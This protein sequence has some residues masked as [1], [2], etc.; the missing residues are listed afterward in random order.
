M[1]GCS[2]GGGGGVW[3]PPAACNS[4]PRSLPF[5]VAAT[6]GE[7]GERGD[8]GAPGFPGRA[9][10]PININTGPSSDAASVHLH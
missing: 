7:K 1:T 10:Q 5:P 9:Q 8:Q 6:K 4:D 2:E 3:L